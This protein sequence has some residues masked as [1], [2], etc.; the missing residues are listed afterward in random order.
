LLDFDQL[1]EDDLRLLNGIFPHKPEKILQV[2]AN[3][4]SRWLNAD[5]YQAA[6]PPSPQVV[7]PRR[8]SPM[9]NLT[10]AFTSTYK[11]VKKNGRKVLRIVLKG[12]EHLACPDSGSDRN[13]ISQEF[14]EEHKIRVRRGKN[15]KKLFELGNGAYIE[16]LGRAYI[17]CSL[18]K[19]SFPE[20]M[21]LCAS[22]LH[23]ASDYRQIILRRNTDLDEESTSP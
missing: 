15:D 3:G 18:A 2:R 17:P 11:T 10:S 5:D 4:G 12:V 1:G 19:G 21:V 7:H 14:A 13:I 20:T 6:K 9:P 16:S 23:S 8:Q 22:K